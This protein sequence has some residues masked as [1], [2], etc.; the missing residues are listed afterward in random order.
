MIFERAFAL[1]VI[2]TTLPFTA[3][4]A[5]PPPSARAEIDYL[6]LYIQTAGCSFYRNGTWYDGPR[7]KEHLKSKYDY[8]AERNQIGAA[9]DFIDKAATKSSMSGNPY[10]IRCANSGE[11]ESGPW[12]RQVLLHHRASDRPT[13]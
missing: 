11:V 1:F 5:E 13:R 7:A 12:L 3:A 4:Q 6:L 9:E 8:L 10:K 2:L